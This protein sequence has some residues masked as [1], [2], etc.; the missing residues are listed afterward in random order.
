M[1]MNADIDLILANCLDSTAR[2]EKTLAECLAEHPEHRDELQA[3]LG[4]ANLLQNAPQV[5][6]RLAFRHS[7]RARLLNQLRVPSKPATARERLGVAWRSLTRP[8]GT[9]LALALAVVLLCVATLFSA[10]VAYASDRAVPGDFLYPLD[11]AVEDVRLSLALSPTQ[12]A[13]LQVANAG[14][15]LSEAA[16]LA[17]AGDE[18][19]L[20][21]AIAEYGQTVSQLLQDIGQLPPEDQDKLLAMLGPILEKQ[22]DELQD[23][24]EA[25]PTEEISGSP[26]TETE[27][28]EATSTPVEPAVAVTPKNESARC[29]GEQYRPVADNLAAIYQADPETILDWFCKGYGFGE[30]ALALKTSEDAGVSPEEL[31]NLKQELGGWGQVWKALGLKGKPDDVGPPDDAGPPDNPG[32]PDK[33]TQKPKDDKGPSGGNGPPE[34]QGNGPPENPGKPTPKPKK[35]P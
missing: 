33:P 19:D 23:L 26:V 28:P 29:D 22:D 10:G 27:E 14:E 7:A 21:T 3:L 2:G 34:N 6:P 15:R 16:Q 4:T 32:K 35:N 13:R 17:S 1:K 30:I 24:I 31:L 12:A 9:R 8:A 18:E 11:R 5:A 20:E 25:I